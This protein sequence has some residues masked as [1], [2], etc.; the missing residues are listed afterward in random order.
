MKMESCSGLLRKVRG[1]VDACT[2]VR[3]RVCVC[4]R[5]CACVVEAA[6]PHPVR[7]RAICVMEAAS[8]RS[9]PQLTHFTS[10]AC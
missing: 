6:S 5:V 10:G 9:R 3:V 4:A 1:V 7:V 2:C 8:P